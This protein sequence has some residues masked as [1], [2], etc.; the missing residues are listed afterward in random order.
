MFLCYIFPLNQGVDNLVTIT[1]YTQTVQLQLD[2][3]ESNTAR[4]KP[5]FLMFSRRIRRSDEVYGMFGSWISTVNTS[6]LICRLITWS[7][8]CTKG[9]DQYIVRFSYNIDCTNTSICNPYV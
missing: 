6:T 2:R 1:D 9:T 5:S 7:G 8:V 3:T 4:D